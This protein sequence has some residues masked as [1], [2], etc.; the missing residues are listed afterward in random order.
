MRPASENVRV[1]RL[2]AVVALL[3]PVVATGLVVFLRRYRGTDRTAVALALLTAVGLCL[4]IA[5][6][7]AQRRFGGKVTTAGRV[8]EA[9][10][11]AGLVAGLCTAAVGAALLAIRWAS[12]QQTSPAAEVWL[13]AFARALATLGVSLASGLPAYLAVGGVLGALA[14]LGTAEIV[15]GCAAP[16]GRAERPAGGQADMPETSMPPVTPAPPS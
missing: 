5:L 6:A 9:G 10:L 3:L 7:W 15:L 1:P 14:G 11:H 4:M 8:R 2:R 12:D 13:E 16:L